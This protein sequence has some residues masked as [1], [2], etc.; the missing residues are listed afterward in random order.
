[1]CGEVRLAGIDERVDHA[2]GSHGLQ[3]IADPGE[4][5]AIID[6]QRDAALF[7]EPA[8]EFEHQPVRGRIDFEDIAFLARRQDERL[9]FSRDRKF[10]FAGFVETDDALAPAP[11]AT[12]VLPRWQSVEKLVGEDDRRSLRR[13]GEARDPS[14]RRARSQQGFVLDFRKSGAGLDERHVDCAAKVGNDARRA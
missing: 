13:L 12:H 4:G 8:G 1:M 2:V 7:D 6:E 10:E 14:D 5:V 9:G 3:R 11:A